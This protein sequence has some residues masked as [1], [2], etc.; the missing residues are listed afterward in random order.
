MRPARAHDRAHHV[1]DLYKGSLCAWLQHDKPV[2]GSGGRGGGAPCTPHAARILGGAR[3]RGR[4]GRARGA[5][6]A[7]GEAEAAPG[8]GS[9]GA[10][11]QQQG[12]APR[13]RT[14]S[15]LQAARLA[16]TPR[17]QLDTLEPHS[18]FLLHMYID[19]LCVLLPYLIST[20]LTIIVCHQI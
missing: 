2:G 16:S 19:F 15:A 10:L 4:A 20:L 5:G 13:P 11:P 6:G 8:P 9:Q 1:I 12:Q 14:V 17:Y 7:Q 3:W 18:V